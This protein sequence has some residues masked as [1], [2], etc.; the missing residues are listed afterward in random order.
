MTNDEGLFDIR[1][2]DFDIRH[3]IPTPSPATY[4][5]GTDSGVPKQPPGRASVGVIPEG[6]RAHLQS[7]SGNTAQ[8]KLAR[9]ATLLPK[10]AAYEPELQKLSDH[11]LRKRSLSLKYR[12]KSGEPLEKILPEAYALVREAGWR[13]ISMRH[14]DVQMLGG[15]ALHHRC[16]AEMQTGEGKTLTATLPCYLNA[17]TGKGVHV[18]TVN[19]YL[20]RRDAEWMRPI[21][22][23]LGLTV[24]VIE[25]PMRRPERQKNYA[26]DIV[27]G[28]AKEFGFDFLRDRLLLRRIAEGQQDLF[29]QMLGTS[30]TQGGE[31]PVQRHAHFGLVDEADSILI[32]E[33]RTPLI[34]SAMPTEEERIA[35]ECF[36]W[37]AQHTGDFEEDV[38]Y[39]S[40]TTSRV[41]N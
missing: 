40:I 25:T 22:E 24:G 9:W 28:T 21:Y 13:T 23:A 38:H 12:A 32:D 8:R 16:I 29:G 15:I 14:F 2:L 11:E 4:N 36:K 35:V 39:S 37:S 34:I 6:F 3:S 18:A 19:D 20:A 30:G 5:Y 26:C 31:E 17:L 7:L 27:Y 33:A 41:S 10:I 1:H